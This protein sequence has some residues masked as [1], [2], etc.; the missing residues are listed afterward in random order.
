MRSHNLCN[1]LGV[2]GVPLHEVTVHH[3]HLRLEL[4]VLLPPVFLE[5]RHC[6][7]GS[8]A[9]RGTLRAGL[10]DGCFRLVPPSRDVP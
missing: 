1:V 7:C 4:C 2:D 8:S 9:E 5:L 10:F 6:F 3:S